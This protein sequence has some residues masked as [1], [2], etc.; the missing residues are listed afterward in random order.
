MSESILSICM[1][2]LGGQDQSAVKGWQEQ[3]FRPEHG[4]NELQELWGP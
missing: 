1:Y 2:E 3:D 4:R